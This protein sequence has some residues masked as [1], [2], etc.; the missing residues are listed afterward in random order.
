MSL[1]ERIDDLIVRVQSEKGVR[2]LA[3]LF[4][5]SMNCGVSSYTC[6]KNFILA[7]ILNLH[8]RIRFGRGDEEEAN[9]PLIQ[10]AFESVTAKPKM[11]MA[12]ENECV[13]SPAKRP[14]FFRVKK[15]NLY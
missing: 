9:H 2:K 3:K 6:D 14:R 1:P 8:F 4:K 10:A 5:I 7:T 12:L 15:S 11:N 13:S